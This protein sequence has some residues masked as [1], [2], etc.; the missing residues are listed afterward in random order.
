MNR[1]RCIIA[2]FFL[3]LFPLCSSSDSNSSALT[4]DHIE[5]ARHVESL[6]QIIYKRAE[7]IELNSEEHLAI[8][9]T[10]LLVKACISSFKLQSAINSM[11]KYLLI[12]GNIE[13][14]KTF[15]EAGYPLPD[16]RVIKFAK[17]IADT[18]EFCYAGNYSVEEHG[19]KVIKFWT[20]RLGILQLAPAVINSM[21]HLRAADFEKLLS[22]SL[23][24]DYR[25]YFKNNWLEIGLQMSNLDV[26]LVSYNHG[27]RIDKRCRSSPSFERSCFAEMARKLALIIA[28]INLFPY[29]LLL[30]Q[31]AS[32]PKS[33]FDNFPKN[34]LEVLFSGF[35][36]QHPREINHAF[37]SLFE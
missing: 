26:A 5:M 9:Q 3:V 15:E 30:L 13:I 1:L 8:V 32:D 33:S 37:N 16:C 21:Y 2:Y 34:I 11:M 25:N 29:F 18:I 7:N 12:V 27:L 28:R 4:L 24:I 23:D 35:V 6:E 31:A 20:C 19:E 17:N 22:K 10:L 14:V 36:F